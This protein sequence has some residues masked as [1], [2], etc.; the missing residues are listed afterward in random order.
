MSPTPVPRRRRR[1]TASDRERNTDTFEPV[2]PQPRNRRRASDTNTT[3]SLAP[4]TPLSSLDN[5][6]PIP[7]LALETEANI[8]TTSKLAAIDRIRTELLEDRY[9][10]KLVEPHYWD[11]THNWTDEGELV[12]TDYWHFL[13]RYE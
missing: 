9:H 5:T 1:R 4:S 6:E 7:D 12:S 2:T 3:G 8:S 11:E 10:E 13:G